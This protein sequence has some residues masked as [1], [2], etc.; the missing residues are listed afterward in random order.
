LRQSRT[1]HTLANGPKSGVQLTAAEQA[2]VRIDADE[3]SATLAWARANE[4]DAPTPNVDRR[5]EISRALAV[6]RSQAKAA[7]SARAALT[8]EMEAAMSPLAGI[9]VWSNVFVAQIV[10][11]E[12]APLLADLIE[13]QRTL[14]AKIERVGQMR[15]FVLAAA[16][17]LPKGSEEARHCYVAAEAL[18]NDMQRATAAHQAPLEDVVAA[19]AALREFVSALAEDATVALAAE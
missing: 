19:R 12:T 1:F 15:E 17:R 9:S 18:A 6:A 2:L 8:A 10:A 13:H 3:A 5:D 16:E 4:G 7:V 11:E 14:A